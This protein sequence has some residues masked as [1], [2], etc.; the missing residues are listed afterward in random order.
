[1]RIT[2]LGSGPSSGVPDIPHGWG[3]CDPDNPKNRRLRQSILVEQNETRLLVD[4]SPDLRQQLLAA[5]VR[6]IDALLYTHAHA[7]HFHGV[8]DLRGLNRAM[9]ADIEAYAD[10][11]TIATMNER[12]GYATAPLDEKAN[13]YYKPMLN[14]HEIAPG[15]A[16]ALGG[17]PITVFDQDHGFS[18]TL[19]FRFGDVGYS[20]DVVDLPEESFAAL[21]GVRLWIL[22]CFQ[23]QPHVTH[24]HVDKAVEWIER[25]G[26]EQAVLTHLS[27][28]IDY[29][30][31]DRYTPDTIS[32][33]FDGLMID[34]PEEGRVRL[35][36]EP[37]QPPQDTAQTLETS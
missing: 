1:M 19:G 21:D 15:D 8:D 14:M 13:I 29:A 6:R 22:S 31:L 16:F 5:G 20:T 25:V 30:E 37:W 26:P 33:A 4:T 17:V 24:V 7:D 18:R 23:W 10:A 2:L 34:V 12:F 3:A 28:R 36:R 9:D 35:G 11:G 27:S 32:P